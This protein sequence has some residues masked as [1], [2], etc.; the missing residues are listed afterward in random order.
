MLQIDCGNGDKSDIEQDDRFSYTC[1]YTQSDYDDLDDD[2]TLQA[3]CLINGAKACTQDV[4]LDPGFLGVCG[5]G[6]RE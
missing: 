1:H 4:T 5:N 6:E 2:K 3:K